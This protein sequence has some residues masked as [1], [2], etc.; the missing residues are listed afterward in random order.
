MEQGYCLITAAMMNDGWLQFSGVDLADGGY[1]RQ[2][3]E[4]LK[5][6]RCKPKC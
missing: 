6:E 2:E 4:R 3:F 5:H 1:V